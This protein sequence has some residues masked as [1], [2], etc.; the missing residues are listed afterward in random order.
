[1]W[2]PPPVQEY[3]DREYVGIF[4]LT[5]EGLATISQAANVSVAEI[6]LLVVSANDGD[7]SALGVLECVGV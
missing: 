3:G 2:P 5:L 7:S 6:C 4:A 1:M